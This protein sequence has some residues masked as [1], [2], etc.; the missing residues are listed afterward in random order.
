MMNPAFM[1]FLLSFPGINVSENSNVV[2]ENKFSSRNWILLSNRLFRAD[3]SSSANGPSAT[4]K[5]IVGGEPIKLK[6]ILII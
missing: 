3:A 2:S 5:S 6:A 1:I 4:N